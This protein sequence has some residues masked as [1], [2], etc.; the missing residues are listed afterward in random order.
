MPVRKT[1]GGIIIEARIKTNCSSFS[2]KKR[3]YDIFIEVSS[4]PLEGKANKEIIKELRKLLNPE[5]VDIVKGLKSKNKVIFVKGKPDILEE[6]VKR[7]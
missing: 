6:A 4:P 7:F 2:I 1:L 5:E 3:G